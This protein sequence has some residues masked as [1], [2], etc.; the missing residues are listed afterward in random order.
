MAGHDLARLKRDLLTKLG[1]GTEA[2]EA[3]WA[4]YC[5]H[6]N[7]YSYDDLM[8]YVPRAERAAWHAKAIEAAKRSDLHSQIGLLLQTKELERLAE[9]VR[10]SKDGTLQ[11]VSHYTTEPA[12]KRLEKPHPDLAARLWCA[13]GMRIVNAKKSKYYGAA[14]RNFERARRGFEQAGLSAEWE[15][16]VE[17][18]RSE[19]RRK[20]GFIAG[21]EEVVAGSGPSEK[22]SFLQRAKA[23]WGAKRPGGARG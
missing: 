11:S 17:K 21:F 15:R 16:I 7:E 12:A 10:R 14:L 5:Q 18:V 8:K 3:A 2:L 19:H 1:R 13:Q 6:P 23:R 4:E 9:L 22:P 20:T